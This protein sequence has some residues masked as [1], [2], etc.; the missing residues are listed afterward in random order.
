MPLLAV[1]LLFGCVLPFLNH[2]QPLILSSLLCAPLCGLLV[3]GAVLHPVL[4]L[5]ER[6][7]ARWGAGLVALML[8]LGCNM[9]KIPCELS[10]TFVVFAVL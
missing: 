8:W 5:N 2:A 6:D 9:M 1:Q 10:R 4:N 7:S 3:S